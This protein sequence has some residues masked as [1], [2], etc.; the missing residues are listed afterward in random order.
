MF[1]FFHDSPAQ[2]DMY[3]KTTDSDVFAL[4]FCAIRWIESESVA[5]RAIKIWPNLL[6]SLKSGRANQRGQGQSM[7]FMRL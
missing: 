7:K 6:K 5:E 1:T 2:P 4:R 3:M